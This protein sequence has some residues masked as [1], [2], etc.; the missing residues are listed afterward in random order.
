M[1][2]NSF[3]R[4]LLIFFKLYRTISCFHQIQEYFAQLFNVFFQ[5]YS[6][7]YFHYDLVNEVLLANERQSREIEQ[8]E[9]ILF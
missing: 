8:D 3:V 9:Q 6:L 2:L 4:T 7:R 1:L 5:L